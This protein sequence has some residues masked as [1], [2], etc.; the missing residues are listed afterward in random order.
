M[1]G[2]DPRGKA[3]RAL[4]VGVSE[5]DHVRPDDR[6]GVPGQLPGVLHNRL[7]LREALRRTGLFEAGHIT[8]CASPPHD[9]FNEALRHAAQETGGLLL[10]YFAGHGIVP[11]AG[12]ELFLQMSNARVVA[13]GHDAFPNA[14]PFTEVLAQLVASRAERVL[15]VLDCCYAGN[16]AAIWH[17]FDHLRR[18]KTLVLMS[19]QS[20]RL[21]D[22]GDGS[23]ATPF[24]EELVQILEKEAELSLGALYTQLKERMAAAGHRTAVDDGQDP[25]G[26]WEPGEDVLLRSAGTATHEPPA[27]QDGRA[28]PRSRRR[29]RRLAAVRSAAARARRIRP[30]VRLLLAL[31]VLVAGCG[32]YGISRLLGDDS[33]CAP[34]LEL[35]VLTDPELE[36]VVTA[37]KTRFLDSDANKEDG[38]HRLG[39]TVYSAGAADTVDALHRQ[40]DPWQDPRTDEENPQR[41]IGPQPDVWIPATVADVSRVTDNRRVRSYARL[42]PEPEPLAYSPVVLA[43]PEALAPEA[44]RRT[45][46]PLAELI[47]ALG[48]RLPAAETRRPDPERSDSALLATAALYAAGTGARDVEQRLTQAAAPSLT[49]AELL[50]DLLEDTAVDRRTAALVPEFLL[51]S[52]TTCSNDIVR[53][54]SRVAEYPR[55]V[56]ALRPAF[57]RVRWQDA[58]RDEDRRNEA[59][60]SFRDWLYGEEGQAALGAAGFRSAGTGHPLL[61]AKPAEGMLADAGRPQPDADGETM[62][63]TLLR[64]RTASGPGRVLFLLD[65][66]GSMATRWKGAS[67]GPG[68]VRKALGALAD[69][70]DE[71]GVWAMYGT[72][73][74]GYAPL[75]PLGPHK[76]A[77]AERIL[78][79]GDLTTVHDTEADPRR[80]LL[81]A[82]GQMTGHDGE[83]DRPQLVVLITD[84]E[85]NNRLTGAD[86]TTVLATARTARIPVAVVSLDGGGCDTSRVDAQLAEASG[87]RC[88][89]AGDDLGT[90]LHDEVARTGMGDG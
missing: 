32:G 60:R 58:D 82:L 64:Y 79:D 65:S 12:D 45:G 25:Q 40:T 10:F 34:P 67:G 16:A 84:D 70:K 36:P 57:V 41:D 14:V 22:A 15:V 30:R 83:D 43:V 18:R 19:V 54:V 42:E 86:R 55:D 85:D 46:R 48:Q 35:R 27:P 90:A 17:R 74:D 21:I 38:C 61:A 53:Q 5:Y 80:A 28:G 1:S 52:G 51:K 2:Y 66:S 50:C 81:A 59:V 24:T 7:R 78:L 73:G 26:V 29:G 89:D 9:V 71:Y 76:K 31:A 63:E 3:N 56:P 23:G 68:L 69:D 11:A 8:L 13:G 39:I 75:L 62:T 49:A 47:R 6:E 4:L 20:N 77:D 33:L 88:L 44:P 72:S 87:G 37:A